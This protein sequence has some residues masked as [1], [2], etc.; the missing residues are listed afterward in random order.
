MAA[1]DNRSL[2][3]LAS[4][5]GR[6]RRI[7]GLLALPLGLVLVAG[8]SGGLTDSGTDSGAAVAPDMGAPGVG[9]ADR[10]SGADE[11]VSGG[12][13]VA[14]D[15]PGGSGTLTEQ[16]V[17]TGDLSVDVEDITSAANR[18]T[19]VVDAA[20]GNVGSDQRYGEATHGSADL[21]VRV[22]PER[23]DELLETISGLGQE[24]SRS[25]A[26]EDV[27]TV[28][29]DVDARV[30]SLQNSVDRLLALAAQAVS[31]S[32][33]ITIEAELSSRQSELESLQAQQ[34][35][36]SDQVSLATLSIRLTAS[37]EPDSDET[38]FLPGLEDGWNALLDFGRGLIS[39]VGV[40]LP[41]LAVIAVI[42]IPAWLLLRRRGNRSLGDTQGPALPAGA[43]PQDGRTTPS[44]GPV[45]QP[46]ASAPVRPPG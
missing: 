23:F 45:S 9:G 10:D 3:N 38:G 20:G 30:E 25:V 39:V 24:Q 22:P 35:A 27:S 17:R 6:I 16:I 15:V 32:D 29:A 2:T 8:C 28:V 19:A 5:T 46:V 44:A 1:S 41:W 40:L 14:E 34:R 18:I 12:G 42:G 26:S 11:S 4:R 36:L 13:G 33:L 43:T 7:G 21:V 31:V 37:S